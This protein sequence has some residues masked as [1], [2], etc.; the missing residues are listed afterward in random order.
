MSYLYFIKAVKAS[1]LKRNVVETYIMEHLSIKVIWVFELTK[2]T[3]GLDKS[4][5]HS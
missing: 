4:H 5:E 1:N 2:Q 3:N